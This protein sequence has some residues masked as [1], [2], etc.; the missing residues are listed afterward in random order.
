MDFKVQITYTMMAAVAAGQL[1]S[2]VCLHTF[3]AHWGIAPDRA[4]GQDQ[5]RIV[6]VRMGTTGTRSRTPAVTGDGRTATLNRGG[7]AQPQPTAKQCCRCERTTGTTP[8][9][10]R[11]RTCSKCDRR[12][13]TGR[14]L[15]S[16]SMPETYEVS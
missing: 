5:A 7:Q 12:V 4:L 3:P 13:D 1:T 11:D 14:G 8:V 2:Y 15:A 6:L 16:Y 9:M 10:N